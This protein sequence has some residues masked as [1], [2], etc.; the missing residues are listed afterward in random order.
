MSPVEFLIK[1]IVTLLIKNVLEIIYKNPE[2]LGD[3][4]IFIKN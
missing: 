1:K 2:I 3:I 4:L